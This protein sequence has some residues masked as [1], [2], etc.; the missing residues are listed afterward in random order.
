MITNRIEFLKSIQPNFI[1]AT[2]NEKENKPSKWV[3]ITMLEPEQIR[4]R[5]QLDKEFILELD[6]K[7]ETENLGLFDTKLKPILEQ[8]EIAYEAWQTHSKSLHI[9]FFFNKSINNNER[10]SWL[11][12][13]FGKENVDLA[14]EKKQIDQAYFTK[15]KQLIAMEFQPHYKSGKE[16]SLYSFTPRKI[17]EFKINKLYELQK[18]T[19][20]KVSITYGDILANPTATE[21]E[22]VSCVMQILNKHQ[23]WKANEILDYVS[24]H[25]KWKNYN[26]EITRK[27]IEDYILPKYS[28]KDNPLQPKQNVC[29]DDVPTLDLISFQEYDDI[30]ENT[31]K[32]LPG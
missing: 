9:N 15:D 28:K 16:K 6:C 1:V 7:T 17:N 18:P 11:C 23:T 12:E 25:N 22:R 13:T 31:H 8:K 14:I 3:D 4:F 19:K 21:Q 5:Q 29:E 27:K 20:R 2:L 24:L 26:P 10:Y 30:F 32:H